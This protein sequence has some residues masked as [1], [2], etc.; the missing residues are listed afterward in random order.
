M[1]NETIRLLIGLFFLLLQASP[2]IYLLF[3]HRRQNRFWA[4]ID[5][6]VN[7]ANKVRLDAQL[8]SALKKLK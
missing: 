8:E 1:K 5:K 3:E 2:L 4:K 6:K 7:E